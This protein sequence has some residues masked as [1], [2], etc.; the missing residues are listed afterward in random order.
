MLDK[1]NIPDSDLARQRWRELREAL[2]PKAI[3]ALSRSGPLKHS[4]SHALSLS[5]FIFHTLL[6]RPQFAALLS[7]QTLTTRPAKQVLASSL[8]VRVAECT[9]T[10]DFSRCIRDFRLFHTLRI[11]LRELEGLARVQDT[12]LEMSN[13]ADVV[14]DTC[15]SRAF[16]LLTAQYGRPMFT[17][18][19]RKVLSR[20]AVLA[21]GKLGGRELNFSSDIDIIYLYDTEKGETGNGDSAGLTNGE[22]YR[23]LSELLTR[24]VA[25]KT[26]HGFGFRVDLG[27]R[28]D[29][30]YG[31]I[32]N[33]LRSLEIYYE[34]WGKLWER[35]VLIKARTCA[36][37]RKLGD[38][39]M[40]TLRP[41]IFRRYLDFTAIEEISLM[42]QRIDRSQRAR[43]KE[44]DDI[45]LGKGG[46]REIEFFVQALQLIHGGKF[47]VLQCR[48]TLSALSRLG[49]AAIIPPE[50]VKILREAYLFLRRLEHRIQLVHQ[51]QTQRL[52]AA[53]DEKDRIARSLGFSGKNEVPVKL[54]AQTLERHREQVHRLYNRLFY[55][56]SKGTTSGVSQEIHTIF[57]GNVPADIA[58]SW[59]QENGFKRP[60]RALT[61]INRLR[62]GPPSAHYV[63]KA[64]SLLNRLSPPLLQAIISSP[65]PDM[66]LAYFQK[67]TEKVGARATFYALLLEN[68]AVLTL[69]AKV[70]GSSK[71][72]S[73]HLILHPELLDELLNPSQFDRAKSLQRLRNDLSEL[74]QA[75]PDDLETQMDIL[76]R[77][78]HAE[79][80]RIGMND[81][82]G[83]LKIS[84]VTDQ[85][86]LVARV[87]LESAYQI[88]STVQKRRYN[89]PDI[90]QAPFIILGMGKLGGGELN[91]SSDLDLIFLFDASENGSLPRK[92]APDEFYAKLA[93]RLLSVMSSRTTEGVLYEIDAR[94]RPSGTFGPLVASFSAFQLYH[95]QSA[96]FWERQALVKAAPVAG[97]RRLF[98]E[99]TKLIADIVYSRSV[100]DKE[101]K[102]F[103]EIREKMAIE[104]ARET[105]DRYHIKCG[106]GGLVDIE[107]LTQYYQLQFGKA[108]PDLRTPNT[109]QA[110][111][112]LK[113]GGFL[114]DETVRVLEETFLFLRKLE[115]RIQI[116][117]NR[118]S[119]FF[120]P[121]TEAFSLLARR[122]DYKKKENRTAAE[123]LFDDYLTAT[124]RVREFFNQALE[125]EKLEKGEK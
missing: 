93:Q 73:Q 47:P 6:N 70:F 59:L 80:L 121:H 75:A 103:L 51:R 74:L 13:L 95:A 102:E 68:S 29:G 94:L 34:S 92:I 7:N 108:S 81:I 96:R 41:F 118:S 123:A 39:L 69:L 105:P 30:Q 22:F 116:L 11:A 85:L 99:I 57:E 72:L 63:P 89:L 38:A 125:V 113:N 60:G 122:M 42:K 35:A 65:D 119:P 32:A 71:F 77:F 52:P 50:D 53:A 87:C 40:K 107:F 100:A 37:H 28:P 16:S 67:F 4:L 115:N 27:L 19:G 55:T 111:R 9:E 90:W 1:T 76:R 110:M 79:L 62:N 117:E 25:E 91:Y 20:F 83:G 43:R 112:A 8:T 66:A 49:K 46:I 98:P 45:K 44:D 21:L 61:I 97:L 24:L 58:A 48:S 86:S 15:L 124:S 78:K 18:R 101:R 14:M 23:R 120:N 104:I 12:M 3:T 64:L 82:Y 84:E 33:S 17:H 5:P 26:E 36:G 2:G 10:E 88:A 114:S 54:L 106:R 109:L 56:P 31:D